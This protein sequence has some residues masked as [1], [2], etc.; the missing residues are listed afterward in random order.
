MSGEEVCEDIP[1][2]TIIAMAICSAGVVSI[3]VALGLAM[4]KTIVLNG[5]LALLLIMLMVALFACVPSISM[6]GTYK[7]AECLNNELARKIN[8]WLQAIEQRGGE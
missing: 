6:Y 2:K 7:Y 8:E 3:V 1:T 5:H 4:L